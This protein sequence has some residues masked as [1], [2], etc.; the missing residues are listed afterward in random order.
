MDDFLC[1]VSRTRARAS[2]EPGY[3]LQNLTAEE[4]HEY[5]DLSKYND[6]KEDLPPVPE[7]DFSV[8]PCPAYV[9]TT[10]TST[11]LETEYAQVSV[12]S[13]RPAQGQS[14]GPA[15]GQGAAQTSQTTQPANTESEYE[16]MSAPSEEQGQRSAADMDS[17]YETVNK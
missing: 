14:Q 6:M 17:Q 15:Q 5:E 8:M 10:T 11:G 7:G 1:F 4:S 2:P 13:M 12:P 3:H 9:P 16:D